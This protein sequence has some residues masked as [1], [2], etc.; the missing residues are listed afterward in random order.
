MLLGVLASWLILGRRAKMNNVRT[1]Y[2][3]PVKVDYQLQQ[4]PQEVNAEPTVGPQE[5]NAEP[6]VR[7]ELPPVGRPQH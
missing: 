2:Y 3:E 6:V 1:S 4:Y 5:V 7:Y